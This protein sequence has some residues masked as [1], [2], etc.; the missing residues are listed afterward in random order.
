MKNNKSVSYFDTLKFNKNLLNSFQAKFLSQVRLPILFILLIIIVGIFSFV[1]IPRRLN[2]QIKIPYVIVSTPLPGAGPED[3]E[4]LVTIPLERKLAGV[5][6]LNTLSSLSQ[7]N[8]SIITLEFLSSKDTKEAV[9]DVQT[10]VN[11]VTNLPAD[12]VKPTVQ[13]IDFENQPFWT[14]AIT[15]QSDTGSLM[16]FSDILKKKIENI[17]SVDRVETSGLED[18]TIE[19]V[20]D[21]NKARE[22]NV[23]PIMISGLV[24][25]AS[26]SYPS[27]QVTNSTSNFSLTINKDI[28]S[29]EDIRNIMLPTAG[30]GVRLGDIAT[31]VERSKSNQEHT[32]I[33]RPNKTSERAVEFFVYKKPNAD[34]EKSYQLTEP[35][36]QNEIKKYGNQFSLFSIF[37]TSQLIVDQFNDLYHEFFNTSVLVFFLL[38]IFLGLRQGIISNVTVPLTF[39]ATFTVIHATGLTLNFLTIFSFLLSLGILIDDTIVVVAA[40]TRYYKTGK[41]TPFETGIMVWK[42]FIVPLWSSA[43]TTVWGFVPLLIASGIIGEFIKS[44]PLIVTTTM[45]SSTL[46]SVL[47][48]IPLMIVF[49]KPTFPKR[50][51]IL[52]IILGILLY[53]GFLILMSPKNMLLPGIITV[54]LIL[55][56]I[57]LRVRKKLVEKYQQLLK[58]NKKVKTLVQ[59]IGQFADHGLINIEKL[60]DAYRVVIEKILRSS[61]ARKKTLIAIFSFTILA[62]L[63]I[64]MGLVKNEF[65]PKSDEDLLYASINLPAGTDIQTVNQEMLNASK[66]LQK[67]T[68]LDYLVSEAGRSFQSTGDRQ[69]EPNSILFTLH[70]T[71]HKER[72]IPSYE[73]ADQVRKQFKAYT[74]GTFSVVEMTSGPPAGADIQITISGDDFSVLDQYVNKVMSY[75]KKQSGVINV[76]KSIKS[77]TSKL[78]FVPDKTKLA[79][80]GLTVDTIGLWLRT[81]ASGFTLDTILFGDKEK[82]I[83]FRTNSYD[84]K[85]VEELS[86]IELPTPMGKTVPLSALGSF[87]LETNPTT[88]TRE[89]QKRTVSVFASAKVGVNIPEK[90]AELLKYADSLK[91]PDGYA[92]KTGGV[93]E[94]NQKSVNSILQAMGL[95]FLLILVT[96]VIEFSSFRQAFIAMLMIPI[97]VAGVFYIFALVR[98]PLSFAALIGVLALFGI[99]MRHAIVVLEKINENRHLGLSLHDAIADAAASR[100]EPVL[101]TSLATIAGLVPITIADPFWRGLGG[102]IISGLLF[103][104]A[105]KLFLVPVLYFDFYKNESKEKN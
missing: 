80:A 99:V 40:M 38:L 28:Q 69:K 43:I 1:Q 24:K 83:I 52:F 31:I 86:T 35:V 61:Q 70:L 82:D 5:D 88:I 16:R 98:V 32:Y 26:Q 37:N 79:S 46:I 39:L 71:K 56:F 72:K 60:S 17:S 58:K 101:L 104:G 100:L 13:S 84:F 95:S 44:I 66:T 12:V 3:V 22:F 103:T 27:G 41:F 11:K 25:S 15:S 54:G 87:K 97:S 96:M 93:N 49:L 94:E 10:E 90:N 45:I 62:Y 91:L 64:P 65:F 85:P 34:I 68:E 7:E 6:G 59:S 30:P 19:V 57:I 102:A 20:I 21:N 73:I 77:G 105:L 42:D 14:F 33:A 23:N 47:I 75:L 36:V 74:K 55:L 4:Q 18:Q 81:Y 53:V 67:T 2:P 48:T 8:V 50:V 76:D 9:N 29:I 92:W 78:V 63:L 51:K 89:N